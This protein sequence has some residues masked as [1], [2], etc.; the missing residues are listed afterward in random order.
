MENSWMSGSWVKVKYKYILIIA[1]FLSLMIVSICVPISNVW[2]SLFPYSLAMRVYYCFFF[3]LILPD[4]IVGNGVISVALID[5]H[6][7]YHKWGWNYVFIYLRV[8]VTP[9]LNEL[10]VHVSGHFNELLCLEN[11]I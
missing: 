5:W 9:F 6:F 7:S 3:F 10:S 4:L 2:E 1:K 8:T 11:K